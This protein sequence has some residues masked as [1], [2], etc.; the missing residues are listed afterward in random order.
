MEAFVGVLLIAALFGVIPAGVAARTGRSFVGWWVYGWLLF[1]V[2]LVHALV[3]TP[4]SV[5]CP[6]CAARVPVEATE[7]RHCGRVGPYLWEYG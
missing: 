1:P 2:A 3:L 4:A 6:G 7:C 5:E